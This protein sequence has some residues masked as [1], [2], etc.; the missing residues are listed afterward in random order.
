VHIQHFTKSYEAVPDPLRPSRSAQVGRLLPSGNTSYTYS[1]N[2]RTVS[3]EPDENGWLEVPE[4][5]GREAC[6]YR[7]NGSGFYTPGEVAQ[8]TQL[9]V[10]KAPVPPPS[11]GRRPARAK[12]ASDDG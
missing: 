7:Q 3:V 5:V 2:G 8:L 12:A 10:V 9:G 1:V 11:A 6:R 4:E